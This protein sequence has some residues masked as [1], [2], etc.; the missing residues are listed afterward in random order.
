MPRRL[1]VDLAGF[2]HII[3]RST[4]TIL[5]MPKLKVSLNGTGYF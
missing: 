2:Y 4:P 1:R 5:S 3:N